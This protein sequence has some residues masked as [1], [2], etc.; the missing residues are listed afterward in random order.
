MLRLP[1]KCTETL[2]RPQEEKNAAAAA[3]AGLNP[4]PLYF[5][6]ETGVKITRYI[7]GAVT[8]DAA[9]ARKPEIMR[10]SAALLRR[11]HDTLPPSKTS[12]TPLRSTTPILRGMRTNLPGSLPDLRRRGGSLPPCARRWRRWVCAAAPATTTPWP[13]IW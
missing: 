8:L 2:D 1:G 11:L 7:R 13:T 6:R 5:S 4:S 3:R 10:K 9:L 12:L